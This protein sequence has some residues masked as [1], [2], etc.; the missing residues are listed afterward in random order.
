MYI[1]IP[2]FVLVVLYLP[3][4]SIQIQLDPLLDS[5]HLTHIPVLYFGYIPRFHADIDIYYH[6]LESEKCKL[7]RCL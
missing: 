2:L 3:W 4:R 7:N 6:L 5:E 1:D